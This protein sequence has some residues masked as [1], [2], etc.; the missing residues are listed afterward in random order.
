[1]LRAATDRDGS[2]TI[3]SVDGTGAYDHVLRAAML[4]RLEKMPGAR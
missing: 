3:L 4:E 1:M 2:A